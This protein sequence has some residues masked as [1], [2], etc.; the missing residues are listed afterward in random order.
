VW[1]AEILRRQ[2]VQGPV[3]KLAEL[4]GGKQ[5]TAADIR[6]AKLSH[7]GVDSKDALDMRVVAAIINKPGWGR[8]N[9]FALLRKEKIMNAEN[10]PYIPYLDKEY[11]KV[12]SYKRVDS[13]NEIHSRIK[14]LV[15]PG[16]GVD[17]IRTLIEQEINNKS[18][19]THKGVENE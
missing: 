6:K 17:F 13:K 11:F 1:I 19:I 14:T 5:K 15:Y 4:G 16:K 10:V 3:E 7:H 2:N 12:F 8:N 9:I 18:V